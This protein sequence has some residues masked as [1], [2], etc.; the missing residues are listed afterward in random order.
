MQGQV[1]ESLLAIVFVLVMGAVVVFIFRWLWNT[2][3]PLVFGIRVYTF[4]Q[5]V[6]LLLLAG[7][8]F[9]GHGAVQKPQHM[10]VDELSRDSQG[11]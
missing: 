2:T 4:G 7:I 8:L 3:M 6:R 5:A 11:Q 1:L 9:G 10:A